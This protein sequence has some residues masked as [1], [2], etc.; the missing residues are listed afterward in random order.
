MSEVNQEVL[1]AIKQAIRLELNGR[2]FYNKAV[3][4]TQN[5]NGRKMFDRLAREE[6]E[7]LEAF[8]KLFTRILGG[9]HWKKHVREEEIEGRAE[10]IERLERK[11][12]ESVG[13]G[14]IEAIRIG[15]ELERTAIDHFG[16]AAKQATEP[17][18]REIFERIRKEEQRHYDLLQAQYDSVTHS[19]FWFDTAE[20]YMDGKY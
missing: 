8:S 2:H 11:K 10:L 19:G 1:D 13:E 9:P 16:N 20:F 18:A 6:V 7:H 17:K 3:E 15:L 12:A 5:E 14:E 4:I